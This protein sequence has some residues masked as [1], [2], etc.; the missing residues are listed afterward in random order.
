MIRQVFHLPLRQ[1][2]G[3]LNG[4]VTALG[5]NISIR[6]FSS[7]SKRS[8]N[9]P[10]HKLT[11]ALEPGSVVIVDSTGFKVYGKDQWHQEKRAVAARRT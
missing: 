11:K 2:Q 4:M 6:D 3:F 9:L 10:R 5:I 8:V 7:L 1:T